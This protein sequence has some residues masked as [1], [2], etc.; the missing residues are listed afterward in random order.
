MT[1]YYKLISYIGDLIVE[2]INDLQYPP[3][4]AIVSDSFM[5]I[6]DKTYNDITLISVKRKFE[7]MIDLNG[8]PIVEKIILHK[9]KKPLIQFY[10]I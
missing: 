1:N 3:Y 5:E 4:L 8:I 6:M 9:E 2:K 10:K 7:G